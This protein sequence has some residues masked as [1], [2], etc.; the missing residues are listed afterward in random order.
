[1]LDAIVTLLQGD[2]TLSGILSGGVYYA[3]EIS[4]QS[5]PDA[6]NQWQELEPCALVKRE[7]QTPWGPHDH[8]ARLYIMVYLYAQLGY[9]EINQAIA[10]IYDLLHRQKIAPGSGGC[11]QIV[12]ANDLLDMEDPELGVAMATSR[13]V[14]TISRA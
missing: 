14:A 1:M 2:S 3:K 12:H 8:S 9:T 11:W 7:T 6:F 4:R 10:R 13:Y 5:T